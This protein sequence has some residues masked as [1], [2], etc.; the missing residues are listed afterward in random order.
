LCLKRTS[1]FPLYSILLSLGNPE[2]DYFSLDVEGA[3]WTIIKSLPWDKVNIHIISLENYY[4]G[5]DNELLETHLE[6]Y[7]YTIYKKVEFDTI[8]VKTK[9]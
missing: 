5:K 2:V 4:L 9:I 7:G 1:C 6:K 3:E 8:F